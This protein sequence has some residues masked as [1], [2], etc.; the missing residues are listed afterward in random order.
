M[1]IR[2]HDPVVPASV[3]AAANV[4]GR[5]EPLQA[6]AGADALMILTPWPDYR[7]I[8]PADIAHSL[9]GGIVLDPYAVLDRTAA[10]TA[11][12]AYYTIGRRAAAS[13]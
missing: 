13:A 2:V 6:T 5:N 9:R 4:I 1:P 8:A 10:E 11:G 7:R 3:A 12:L